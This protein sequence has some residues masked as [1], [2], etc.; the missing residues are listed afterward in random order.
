MICPCIA[1]THKSKRRCAECADGEEYKRSSRVMMRLIDD[2]WRRR[3]DRG[4]GSAPP[5]TI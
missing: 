3:R 2:D 5:R 4:G 1:C